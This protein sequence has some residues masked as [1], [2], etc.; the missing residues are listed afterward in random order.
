MVCTKFMRII[1]QWLLVI[2]T[3]AL[4]SACGSSPTTGSGNIN[5]NVKPVE[6]PEAASK[7]YQKVLAAINNKK[8]DKAETLLIKL[9]STYPELLSLQVI[10]GWV[11]WQAGNAEKAEAQLE[12]L[13]KKKL[14]KPDAFVYLA[15]IYRQQGKFS[16]AESVY[17]KALKIWPGDPV[18]HKNLGILYE[19]YLGQLENARASYRQAQELSFKDKQL[20]G[21]VKD[22]TRR[23]SK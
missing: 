8:W 20:D 2:A 17:Q 1:T 19:L 6:V 5:P 15:V 18:L 11:H 9:Q 23:T 4:I 10:T 12:G 14:Y 16:K 22:L 21:W 3:V 7:A 13:T